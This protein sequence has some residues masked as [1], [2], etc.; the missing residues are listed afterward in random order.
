MNRILT[1]TTFFILSLTHVFG[2]EKLVLEHK[3]KTSKKKYIDLNREYYIKTT[4][5]SY[6]SKI[7]EFTDTTLSIIG[8]VKTN[9]DTAYGYSYKVSKTKDTSYTVVRPLY[10][11]DTTKILFSEIQTL[12]KDWFKNRRWLEPF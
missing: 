4:D 12:K 9:R 5:T 2:Q 11:R 8:W 6:Y 1:I 3:K 7:V 10:K